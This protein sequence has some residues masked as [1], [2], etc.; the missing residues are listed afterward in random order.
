MTTMP[1][2]IGSKR[3]L[4]LVL[5]FAIALPSTQI[6]YAITQ[7]Y[8]QDMMVVYG[9]IYMVKELFLYI[10][11]RG[12]I[13]QRTRKSAYDNGVVLW[14]FYGRLVAQFYIVWYLTSIVNIQTLRRCCILS[15]LRH[16]HTSTCKTVSEETL[17]LKQVVRGLCNDSDAQY[18]VLQLSIVCVIKPFKI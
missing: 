11:I 13:C 1:L 12:Y 3:N 16:S 6:L 17:S 7:S 9:V 14:S 4:A 2:F 5:F 8:T 15:I 18:G 10:T